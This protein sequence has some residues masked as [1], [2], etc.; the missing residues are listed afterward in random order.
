MKKKDNIFKDTEGIKYKHPERTCKDC[1]K[2]PCMKGM[3]SFKCDFAKYGCREF[4]NISW[5]T[6]SP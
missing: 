2:Y 6:N 3:D 4:E 1:E 5:K